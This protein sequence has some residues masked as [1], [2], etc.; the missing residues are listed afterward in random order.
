VEQT[1]G[2]SFNLRDMKRA[3]GAAP[4]PRIFEVV[5][6][7]YTL[8]LSGTLSLGDRLRIEVRRPE[9]LIVSGLPLD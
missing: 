4:G 7:F 6:S 3:S 2:A 9:R 8:T 1:G 5:R